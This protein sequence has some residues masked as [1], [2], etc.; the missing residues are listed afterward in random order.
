MTLVATGK[1]VI[2]RQ[3]KAEQTTASGLVIPEQAQHKPQEGTVVSVADAPDIKV[4]DKVLF[5]QYLSIEVGHN[6]E[7]FIVCEGKD[8]IAIVVD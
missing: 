7:T 3:D 8:I 4:G 5:S 1:R 6:G 2:I